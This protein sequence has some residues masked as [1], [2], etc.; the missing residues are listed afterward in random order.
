MFS[1]LGDNYENSTALVITF[2]MNNFEQ[3]ATFMT[4]AKAWEEE[5]IR[6]LKN[7][8]ESTR[9]DNKTLIEVSFMAQVKCHTLCTPGFIHITTKGTLL[10]M[11]LC[12]IQLNVCIEQ[13][14]RSKK[15]IGVPFRSNINEPRQTQ[16]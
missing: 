3:N 9:N 14:Q 15:K 5:F 2:A 16:I 10:L 4:L 11:G 13:Q 1:R 8:T 7:F 6:I 12:R